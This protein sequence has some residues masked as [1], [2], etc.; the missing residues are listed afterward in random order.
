MGVDVVFGLPGAGFTIE[1]PASCG[2]IM[3]QALANPGPVVVKAIVDPFVP[4]AAGEDQFKPSEQIRRIP[5][6]RRTGPG[7]DRLDSSVG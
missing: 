5:G 7:Q 2:A 6:A 1:N 3:D 4:R